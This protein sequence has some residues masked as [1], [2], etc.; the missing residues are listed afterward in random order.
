M[1]LVV[2]REPHSLDGYKTVQTI[3]GIDWG[4]VDCLVF[5]SS[6][7]SDLNVVLELAK[8]TDSVQ[9]FLYVANELNSVFC[10]IFLGLGADIYS[11]D[12]YLSDKDMLDYLVDNYRETGMTDKTPTADIDT[13]LKFVE[14]LSQQ[15]PDEVA[16]LVTNDIWLKTLSNAATSISKAIARTDES[17]SQVV[18]LFQKTSQLFDKLEQS[19]QKS[20]ED[21]QHL[22]KMLQEAEMTARP[23]AP[24]M[25]ST[26]RVPAIAQN[27][28][29][30]REYGHCQFLHTFILYY[31]HYLKMTLQRKCKVLF[32]MPKL[33]VLMQKYEEFPRL[34]PDSINSIDLESAGDCFVTFEPK[35]M[36]LNAFFNIGAELYI[37][38]DEMFGEPLVDGPTVQGFA[39]I[40][41]I[42]DTTKFRLSNPSRTIAAIAGA[43]GTLI[44]PYIRE[45]VN[46]KSDTQRKALYYKACSQKYEMLDKLFFGGG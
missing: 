43:K 22:R 33:K 18:A 2:S 17:N 42:S 16:K 13:L 41:G 8:A 26:Y 44:I 21:L 36:V 4:T 12:E 31:Q 10:C 11:Q 39:A 37:V 40:S 6:V 28:M 25:F 34:A 19:Q 38:V 9:K 5:N 35:Q 7:D 1:R 14:T 24:F 30:I 23:S 45:V 15:S 29:Y 32:A 20:E 3:Q 46:T 27:V